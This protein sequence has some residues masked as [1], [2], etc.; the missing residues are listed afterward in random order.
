MRLPARSLL[1]CLSLL[2]LLSHVSSMDYDDD[3]DDEQIS[4]SSVKNAEAPMGEMQR[5]I[6]IEGSF[7]DE[8][9]RAL[10][11]N[12]ILRV[13]LD[14]GKQQAIARADGSFTIYDVSEGVHSL[15]VDAPGW[16]FE[17]IKIDVHYKRNELKVRASFNGDNVGKPVKYP[18]TLQ[19]SIRVKYFEEREK[20]DPTV[21]LK[22][23]MV[24]MGIIA[25][26]MA[27]VMPKMVENMDPEEVK[28]LREEMKKTGGTANALK[29]AMQGS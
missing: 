25:A 4:K 9:F 11:K 2:A 26:L 20:F 8:Q 13:M 18:L 3:E 5:S 28:K 22:N 12:N 7:S 19:P 27:F 1:L 10:H 23:P 16:I 21:Y 17:Q 14:G 15:D 29:S 24:V 6:S